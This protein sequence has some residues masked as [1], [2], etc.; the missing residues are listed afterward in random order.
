LRRLVKSI[1]KGFGISRKCARGAA[2]QVCSSRARRCS[3]LFAQSHKDLDT[4]DLV[5]VR[6]RR[7]LANDYVRTR[8]I[9][10]LVLAFYQEVRADVS[11]EIN[12]GAI[13]CDWAQQSHKLPP[14]K[15]QG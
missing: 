4:R 15:L 12:A 8:N 14:K 5:A 9:N 10:E 6:R 1:K 2:A 7:R 3:P 13:D 11:V